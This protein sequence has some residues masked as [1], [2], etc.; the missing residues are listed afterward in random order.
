M[1]I[2]KLMT[3]GDTAKLIDSIAER[4]VTLQADI[5]TAAVNTF[6]HAFVHGDYT[7][8]TRLMDVLPNGQRVKALAFWY[9]HFS[10]GALTLSVDPETKSWKV[11]KDRFARRADLVPDVQAATDRCMETTFADLTAEKDPQTLTLERFLKSL[12][13]TATNA[14]NFDGT[15]IPKV[16]PQLRAIASKLVGVVESEIAASKAA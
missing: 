9:S 8:I 13:R 14:E 3:Q 11:N 2:V 5:H 7:L 10:N 12:K 1:S 6:N 16:S 4:G 15:D